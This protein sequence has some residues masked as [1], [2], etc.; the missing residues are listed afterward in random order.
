MAFIVNN[1]VVD[2]K[3]D[4]NDDDV[5]NAVSVIAEE[6]EL[7]ST[8]S[9]IQNG[10]PD[11]VST[12]EATLQ[13]VAATSETDS[14]YRKTVITWMVNCKICNKSV[15]D[16][17]A[18]KQIHVLSHL[19]Q[20]TGISSLFECNICWKQNRQWQ[21]VYYAHL[22]THLKKKHDVSKPT[23]DDDYL[24]K[25][26]AHS[27]QIDYTMEKCF[28]KCVRY[29]K[30]T[31]NVVR[32]RK[33]YVPPSRVFCNKCQKSISSVPKEQ[34][35]HAL[36][37]LRSEMGMKWIYRCLL[38]SKNK[39]RLQTLW[40]NTL[41]GH[42]K[43]VH[44]CFDKP[45][46]GR[47]YLSRKDQLASS[48]EDMTCLCFGK[49][50]SAKK[51]RKPTGPR[52]PIQMRQSNG[53]KSNTNN[54]YKIKSEIMD[55]NTSHMFN[56]GKT[57]KRKR[58][59]LQCSKCLEFIDRYLLKPHCLK[60]LKEDSK[61]L[62]AYKCLLCEQGNYV[63]ASAV[64]A[65]L[66][67]HHEIKVAKPGKDF[68]D[69]TSDLNELISNSI[70]EYFKIEF[71]KSNI[72]SKRKQMSGVGEMECS[73]CGKS[74]MGNLNSLKHHS[75][76]H[77]KGECGIDWLYECLLCFDR[78]PLRTLRREYMHKHMSGAHNI[79]T[80]ECGI[81]YIDHSAN[82]AEKLEEITRKCFPSL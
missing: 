67:S 44:R 50:D 66:F 22:A 62:W 3:T 33:Q 19:K 78:D 24:D 57:S 38:C 16:Y 15:V 81:H 48:I 72:S 42:L 2:I 82:H 20:E 31:C 25:T 68:L 35:K 52:K 7:C 5:Q 79:A 61:I 73:L 46:L 69:L 34:K 63:N 26:N 17:R 80:P 1:V 59:L 53:K 14:P 64:K 56:V 49:K 71:G 6:V 11:A 76:C 9:T 21:T 10:G 29:E 55:P 18:L 65:H 8:P 43:V 60:H 30:I 47:N 27:A 58:T 32:R 77:I 40:F 41:R 54:V 45:S 51:A 70:Y 13:P 75:M 37:H 23:I 39:R 12:E 28:D 4:Q 36:I 74:I